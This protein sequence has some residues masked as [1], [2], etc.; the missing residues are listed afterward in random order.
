MFNNGFPK[1][2]EKIFITHFI[3]LTK[4]SFLNTEPRSYDSLISAPE[5]QSVFICRKKEASIIQIHSL[6]SRA[7][8]RYFSL[9]F[10]P[11]PRADAIVSYGVRSAVIYLSSTEIGLIATRD[12]I[13]F[14]TVKRDSKDLLFFGLGDFYCPNLGWLAIFLYPLSVSHRRNELPF[15]A[16]SALES[17]SWILRQY[18]IIV[19]EY[20]YQEHTYSHRKKHRQ[21]Y[22]Q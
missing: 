6:F 18:G 9:Q 20:V 13:R 7:S 2:I 11:L 8:G 15:S 17:A 21:I 19:S 1:G 22:E 3:F 5:R 12:K 4:I 14:I 10:I 16:H